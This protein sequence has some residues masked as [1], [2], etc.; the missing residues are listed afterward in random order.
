MQSREER[1]AKIVKDFGGI[2]RMCKNI[3]ATGDDCGL[4]ESDIVAAATAEACK[5]HIGIRSDSAFAKFVGEHPEVLR[6]CSV[7][8]AF[9]NQMVL[10]PTFV[11][12]SEAQN[13]PGDG[14]NK[15]IDALTKL[16]EEQHRRVSGS[17][18]KAFADIYARNPELARREREENRPSG[19]PSYPP[20]SER[21]R[22]RG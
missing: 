22:V 6:A 14:R 17:F 9:P 7:A 20:A 5:F 15:A 21:E 3:A 19:H 12:Q 16:A 10:T 2:I 18:S 13:H 1:I 4:T 8:K 11:A